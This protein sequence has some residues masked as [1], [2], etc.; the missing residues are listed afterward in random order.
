MIPFYRP[1]ALREDEVAWINE[2]VE[3]AVRS[4]RLTN[5]ENVREFEQQVKILHGVEHV[6]A[7]SSASQAL[8]AVLEVLKPET[9][10]VQAFTW[11]SIKH[12]LPLRPVTYCDVDKET[13]LMNSRVRT[14]WD[15]L[16]RAVIYTHTFGNM[17]VATVEADE[18]KVIYDGAY[19]LGADLPEIG[20]ATVISA[21]V[22]KTITSCEGGLILTNDERLA[23]E[24]RQI[25]DMCSRMS[26]LNAIVGL[27]YLQRLNMII[28]RKKRIFEYYQA[29]L[30][31]QPQKTTR[32]GTNYGYYSCLV[33]NRDELIKRLNG[34]VETRIRY[35]PIEHGLP[36]TD[37]IAKQVLTLP[38]YPDLNEEEVVNIISECIK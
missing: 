26:E 34:K 28:G 27:A 38:C 9:L 1:P 11:Q 32:W 19:S 16:P 23:S 35:Q 12:V 33:S 36:V 18:Q 22:T 20:D 17:G 14:Y 3:K 7:C 2:R 24:V 4:G 30:P 15:F 21:S 5:G 10:M 6:V 29:R 31:F 8:S 13:W 37:D 25:R